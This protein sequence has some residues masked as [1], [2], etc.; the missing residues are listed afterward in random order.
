VHFHGVFFRDRELFRLFVI[1]DHADMTG[2]LKHLYLFTLQG[3]LN[4]TV[5][6]VYEREV[7]PIISIF[8]GFFGKRT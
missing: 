3:M 5:L 4:L 7:L 8:W 2:E 1:H 6:I